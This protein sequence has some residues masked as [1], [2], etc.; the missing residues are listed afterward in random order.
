MSDS[1]LITALWTVSCYLLRFGAAFGFFV[2]IC[3]WDYG[4]YEW[5]WFHFQIDMPT[6][7]G[8]VRTDQTN[9]LESYLSYSVETSIFLPS[10]LETGAWKLVLREDTRGPDFWGA[11]P[12]HNALWF[13]ERAC[14]IFHTPYSFPDE[15]HVNRSSSQVDL[16]NL[17]G[18]LQMHMRVICTNNWLSWPRSQDFSFCFGR[19]IGDQVL[20]E[21]LNFCD[22]L[23][24]VNKSINCFVFISLP[25]TYSLQGMRKIDTPAKTATKWLS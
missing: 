5:G 22:F 7:L 23:T 13:F 2:G 8:V 25:I 20:I 15:G 6:N 12:W 11:L 9:A 18:V 19:G 3:A 14:G 24:N 21:H 1:T 16:T 10:C 4:P 17:W